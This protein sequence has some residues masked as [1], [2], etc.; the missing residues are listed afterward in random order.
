MPQIKEWRRELIRKIA[1][2]GNINVYSLKT[3]KFKTNSIHI[4]FHDRLCR[5][6]ASLNAILPSVLK[7]GSAALPTMR[8]IS[9]RLEELYGASFSC[10]TQKKGERQLLHFYVDHVSDRYTGKGEMLFEKC[11]TL[12]ADMIYAPLLE[13]GTF[14]KEYVLQEKVNQKLL[15]ESRIN[16]KT[17]YA[18]ER[19][20]E[21]MCAEEPY[22]IYECGTVEDLNRFDES[23][24]YRHYQKLL[25]T[26]PA[27]IFITGDIEDKRIKK[28]CGRIL[29]TKRAVTSSVPFA[30][31]DAGIS[32][33]REV[34]EDLKGNQGKLCIGYRTG[35]TAADDEYYALALCNGIL[36]GGGCL[37][38]KLFQNVREKASLAYYIYSRID[39]FKGVMMVNCGI[40][41]PN[42]Q[43]TFDIIQKQIDD[44]KAGE[45]TEYEY[46][47]TL[48]TIHSS[49]K[50]LSDSAGGMVDYY[51]GQ[52]VTG[53]A[54]IFKEVMEKFKAVSK[55]D[56]IKAA[57]LI[58]TDT[59]YFL[60]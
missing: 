44:I 14:K 57:G 24:L 19:C 41:I 7:M 6:N 42:R 17:Q 54:G 55:E 5:E 27:D 15:I 23:S 29:G 22:G 12:L 31:V 9:V 11:F 20:T 50:A 51:L 36:G 3:D 30:P 34:H 45:I 21:I 26:L 59:I 8:D 38:S 33:V 35:I 58:K 32:S 46:K 1:S 53:K 10:G 47:A 49:L 48:K 52:T 4:Y 60:T 28:V 25:E 56:I 37:H 18:A 39:K 40:D 16:D 13:N 2:A 43:K